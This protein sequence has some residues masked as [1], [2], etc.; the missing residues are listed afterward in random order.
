MT[1]LRRNLKCVL[2][3]SFTQSFTILNPD[4]TDFDFTGLTVSSV[5]GRTLNPV[6][7]LHEVTE[8]EP[9]IYEHYQFEVDVTDNVITISLT[10]GW[11]LDY[12]KYVYVVYYDDDEDNR[13][14]I[15]EGEFVV[16]S[17]PR[18]YTQELPIDGEVIDF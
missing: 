12:G 10:G 9:S 2:G 16:H 1:I 3:D 14:I 11:S 8:E 4:G 15:I 18:T 17:D 13:E 5:L 6:D 7:V